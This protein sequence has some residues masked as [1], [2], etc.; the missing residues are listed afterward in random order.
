[1]E[2][3]LI[4]LLLASSD[5]SFATYSSELMSLVDG[6]VKGYVAVS[7]GDGGFISTV[8][9]ADQTYIQSGRMMAQESELLSPL[10]PKVLCTM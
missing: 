10:L 3:Y 2:E 7:G 5:R 1:M 9:L 8:I 6:I 4:E